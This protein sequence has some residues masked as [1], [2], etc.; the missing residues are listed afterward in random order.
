M[1]NRVSV[2]L[3][4]VVLAGAA[5]CSIVAVM[6][7]PAGNQP[8]P[9]AETEGQAR[10]ADPSL[11]A[12]VDNV[13]L[14]RPF[15]LQ[16]PYTHWWRKER[17]QVASGYLFV[18]RVHPSLVKPRQ[19]A[20]PVLYVGNQTAERLNVGGDNGNI[21]VIVPGNVDPTQARFWFGTRELPERIDA[22]AITREAALADH[23]GIQKPP[24]AQIQAA[25]ANGGAQLN[26][27]DRTALI[28]AAVELIKLH[29]PTESDDA[30]RLLPASS[31]GA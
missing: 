2:V 1:K 3:G 6:A 13:V 4:L 26:V 16:T 12:A 20:E 31:I 17:P 9:A 11:P 19:S 14:A 5:A 10:A 25:I 29:S 21:V 15:Q 18:L 28:E 24:A 7:Q 30:N 22:A 27:T 8:T 23:A